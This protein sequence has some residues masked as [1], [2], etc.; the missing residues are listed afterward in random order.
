MYLKVQEQIDTFRSDVREAFI[1][2]LKIRGK[3]WYLEK[4]IDPED[5]FIDAFHFS[6]TKEGIEY[7]WFVSDNQEHFK[8]YY[9][10]NFIVN[11][12]YKAEHT[13]EHKILIL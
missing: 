6:K 3:L 1:H 9:Y 10:H 12:I 5:L 13:D 8:K 7:W 2:N 11:E 4:E